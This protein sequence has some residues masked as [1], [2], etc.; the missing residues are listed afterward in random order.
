MGS[1]PAS[2]VSQL[3]LLDFDWMAGPLILVFFIKFNVIIPKPLPY[4]CDSGYENY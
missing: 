2:I 4:V 3:I 1:K